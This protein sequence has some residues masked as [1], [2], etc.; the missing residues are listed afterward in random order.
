MFFPGGLPLYNNG[1]LMGAIGCSGGS[2][3]QD[4]LIAKVGVEWLANSTESR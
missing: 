2:P 1:I 4:L 3:D